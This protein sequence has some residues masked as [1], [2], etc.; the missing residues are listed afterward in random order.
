[1]RNG[2]RLPAPIGAMTGLAGLFDQRLPGRHIALGHFNG[3]VL[4]YP[5]PSSAYDINTMPKIDFFMENPAE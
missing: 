1:M 5:Q 3:G 2:R 4:F